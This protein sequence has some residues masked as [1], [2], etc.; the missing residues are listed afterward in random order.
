[1]FSEKGDLRPRV[2]KKFIWSLV[3]PRGMSWLK[4]WC[5]REFPLGRR[6]KLS[7]MEEVKKSKEMWLWQGTAWMSEK[8]PSPSPL[9]GLGQIHNKGWTDKEGQRISSLVLCFSSACSWSRNEKARRTQ[10]GAWDI[11]PFTLSFWV[12]G[13]RASSHS[14]AD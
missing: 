9:L 6:R 12:L 3:K 8:G 10:K 4:V 1:M 11:L 7:T 5:K 2:R 13:W 14:C